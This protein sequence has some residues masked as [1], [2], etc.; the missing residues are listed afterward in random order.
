MN[1]A[2]FKSKMLY[3]ESMHKL[4]EGRQDY[5]RGYMR[6]LRRRYHGE[7]FGTDDEH[8]QYLGLINDPTRA[9]MGRGYRDGF[10]EYTV[11]QMFCHRCSHQWINRREDKPRVCPK[12]KSPWWDK[13]RQKPLDK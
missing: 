10:S 4:D 3:A 9:E 5:W 1:E 2:Q 11:T 13:K 7:A 12:C 8:Q 6:G